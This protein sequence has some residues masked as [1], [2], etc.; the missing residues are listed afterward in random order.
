[1]I[2]A[3][4]ASS[5]LAKVFAPLMDVLDEAFAEVVRVHRLQRANL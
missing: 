1:M 4:I 3:A 2:M 5:Q